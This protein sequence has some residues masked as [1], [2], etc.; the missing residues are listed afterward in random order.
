M[1][2]LGESDLF[3]TLDIKVVENSLWGYDKSRTDFNGIFIQLLLSN[4][5]MFKTGAFPAS[6]LTD[7]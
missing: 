1:L 4:C 5:F 6:L 3:H 2:Y 7:L